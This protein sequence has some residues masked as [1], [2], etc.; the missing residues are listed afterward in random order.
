MCNSWRSAARVPIT[1]GR[2]DHYLTRKLHEVP[3][4]EMV[5]VSA[6]YRLRTTDENGCNW[7][8]DVVP[9][10]GIRAP[11]ASLITVVLR[12]IVKAAQERFNLID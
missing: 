4:F 11:L 7:S 12:P 9:M 8:G 2:L 5:S 3:G 10:Y 1:P 6:G